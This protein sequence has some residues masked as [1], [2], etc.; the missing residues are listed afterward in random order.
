MRLHEMSMPN[1]IYKN[2]TLELKNKKMRS[3]Q[4]Y[5]QYEYKYLNS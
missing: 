5:V 3:I 4:G 2:Q 1:T